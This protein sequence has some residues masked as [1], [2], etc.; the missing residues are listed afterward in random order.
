MERKKNRERG[1]EQGERW[2]VKQRE[3]ERERVEQREKRSRT[4]RGGI[5]QREGIRTDR[6]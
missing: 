6:E 2:E 3:R 1:I 5:E 4:E